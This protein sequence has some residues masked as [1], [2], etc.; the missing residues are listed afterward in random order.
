[1]INSN[2]F[3]WIT[4]C[5][6][7]GN[8][9]F[10]SMRK[11]LVRSLFFFSYLCNDA[12]LLHNEDIITSLHKSLPVNVN[13]RIHVS[14]FHLPVISHFLFLYD[15][16]CNTYTRKNR[17]IIHHVI[18]FRKKKCRR[19]N[20]RSWITNESLLFRLMKRIVHVCWRKES[21]STQLV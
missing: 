4:L 21:T 19:T 15:R 14:L 2:T 1:M 20:E 12:S 13:I 17:S 11:K 6:F 18:Y 9:C 8:N 5:T 7:H 16:L 10:I 3:G